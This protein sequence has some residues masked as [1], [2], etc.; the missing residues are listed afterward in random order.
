MQIII[1]ERSK[2][3]AKNNPTVFTKTFINLSVFISGRW[4]LLF[5]SRYFISFFFGMMLL[6]GQSGFTERTL[7]TDMES[8]PQKDKLL[9]NCKKS[10][11]FFSGTKK[12]EKKRKLKSYAIQDQII[13]RYCGNTLQQI[14]WFSCEKC[15]W[16]P[17]SAKRLVRNKFLTLM[18]FSH[19]W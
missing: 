1:E 2:I 18:R 12:E 19:R 8:R 10:C 16:I 9:W 14:W 17:V 3:I 4:A 11:L 7:K 5:L 15:H 13:S 6:S